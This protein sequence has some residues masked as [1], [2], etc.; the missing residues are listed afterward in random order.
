MLLAE[1]V[2]KSLRNRRSLRGHD[3]ASTFQVVLDLTMCG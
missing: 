1:L 2:W 3:S